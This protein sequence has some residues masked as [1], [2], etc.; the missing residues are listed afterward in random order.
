[1]IDKNEVICMVKCNHSQLEDKNGG[2]SSGDYYVSDT[3]M[4]LQ[5]DNLST[6]DGE[7][8]R[9]TVTKI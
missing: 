9:R 6:G 7:E 4:T 3:R 2:A 8:V 5:G 1:M